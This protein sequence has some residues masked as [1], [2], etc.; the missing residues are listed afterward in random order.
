MEY[1]KHTSKLIGERRY[2]SCALLKGSEGEVLVA[3]A[4]GT[5][6]GMEVWNPSDD[7]VQLLTPDFPLFTLEFSQ[8]ISVNDHSELIFYES[9][10]PSQ[11]KGITHNNLYDKNCSHLQDVLLSK[12]TLF[13]NFNLKGGILIGAYRQHLLYV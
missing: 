13:C 12:E 11:A 7:S 5:S 2:S 4:G 3:V 8:M 9:H 1:T 6:A 10:S